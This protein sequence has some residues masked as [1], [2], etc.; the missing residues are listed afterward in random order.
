MALP[1]IAEIQPE[2]ESLQ[3]YVDAV[4]RASVGD[5]NDTEIEALRYALEHALYVLNQYGWTFDH[6]DW[7]SDEDDDEQDVV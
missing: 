4:D 6:K 3:E 1:T 2:I 7:D 5:S